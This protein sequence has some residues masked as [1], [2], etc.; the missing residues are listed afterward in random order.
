V[1]QGALLIFPEGLSL[2]EKKLKPLKTGAAR[3]A[4][5]AVM[6]A[7]FLLEV[8]IVPIGLNYS[9]PHTFRSDLFV[10]VGKPILVNDFIDPSIVGDKELEIE[11]AR[12]LTE[13]L[14][15]E[16]QSCIL[17]VESSDEELLL[18]KLEAVFSTE[19]HAQLQIS[20]TNQAGEFKIQKDF[21]DA[22]QQ[23]KTN[24]P[25][26]FDEI[27][28]QVD[29]YLKQLSKLDLSDKDIRDLEKRAQQRKI[30][31]L[32]LGSPF[33][34][35]GWLN[36]Y[37]P[38][39]GVGMIS[40]RIKLHANFTGS[41]ILAVG[42]FTF[43]IWYGLISFVLGYFI[44]GWPAVFYPILMYISGV[45]ALLYATG[46]AY[47]L[48][49]KKLRFLI[50]SNHELVAELKQKRAKIISVLLGM[51]AEYMQPKNNQ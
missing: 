40:S 25:I 26:L 6:D 17:H 33:F 1:N 27:E 38:Y 18:A 13:A 39:K 8:E 19:V 12:R 36:N 21:I 37:I 10:N 20:F 4:I 49:R 2:T 5:G 11:A 51:Q 14:E 48:K 30:I 42:L 9:D 23:T 28:H 7:D 45:Y 43:L 35:L 3:I 29:D 16:L 41:I 50:R 15:I 47:S 44:L 46:I 24:S 22:I 32:I 34:A 31:P